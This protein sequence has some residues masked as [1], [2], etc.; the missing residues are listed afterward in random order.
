MNAARKW[1]G[2]HWRD[3]RTT[4]T[5]CKGF[6]SHVN[7][8]AKWSSELVK[9]WRP[10]SSVIPAE[11]GKRTFAPIVTNMCKATWKSILIRTFARCSFSARIVARVLDWKV[12]WKSTNA[13]VVTSWLT[14]SY[15]WHVQLDQ[16]S[17]MNCP[18][19]VFTKVHIRDIYLT[20]QNCCQF[21]ICTS[22]DI[23]FECICGKPNAEGVI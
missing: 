3:T 9:I 19:I 21:T 22:P 1:Q 12:N 11:Q 10:T 17:T 2:L 20:F 13:K 18:C 7:P 4:F 23:A 15:G 14:E 8:H 6:F 5:Q 16:V